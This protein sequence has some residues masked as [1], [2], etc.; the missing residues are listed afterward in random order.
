MK[1]NKQ[2]D[3]RALYVLQQA[4]DN[5]IFPRIMDATNAKDVWSTLLEEFKGS[6]KVR[7]IKLQILRISSMVKMDSDADFVIFD[8]KL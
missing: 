8:L 6:D 1:E 4:V 5:T 2:K 7:A 3:S